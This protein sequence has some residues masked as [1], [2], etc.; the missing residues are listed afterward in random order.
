MKIR[1]TKNLT[2]YDVEGNK[3]FFHNG[4]EFVAN[5]GK[6]WGRSGAWVTTMQDDTEVKFFV[7]KNGYEQI[8]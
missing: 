4:Q 3:R 1:L 6:S 5:E 7:S 2:T 8:S